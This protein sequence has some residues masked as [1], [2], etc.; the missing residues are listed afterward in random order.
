MEHELKDALQWAIDDLITLRSLV[1]VHGPVRGPQKWTEV[2][3]PCGV[4]LAAYAAIV[5][6]IKRGG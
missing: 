2:H 3:E 5:D 4:S 1:L 6:D